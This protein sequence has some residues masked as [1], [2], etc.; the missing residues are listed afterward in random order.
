MPALSL[1]QILAPLILTECLQTRLED[2][3]A[4]LTSVLDDTPS[5]HHPV[6]MAIIDSLS[7][8]EAAIHQLQFTKLVL[9]LS[10][11]QQL[12]QHLRVHSSFPAIEDVDSSS[13]S[14]P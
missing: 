9:H 4:S 1:Q 14:E 6:R 10:I 8:L 13:D 11:Q 12:Q 7:S 5:C 3:V 2:H